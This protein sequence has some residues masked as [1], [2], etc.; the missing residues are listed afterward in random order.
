[1]KI[2]KKMLFIYN[3]H[4]GKAAIK[5]KLSDI[6]ELFVGVDY[7]VTIFSTREKRDAT[8]IVKE[9][10][11][12]Y[13]CIVCS[14]GDG[15]LN[16]VVDGL[17]TLEKR[18]PC[19][20]MP[21]GTVNDFAS[22]LKIPKSIMVAAQNVIDGQPFAYDIG[23]LNNDHF[24]YVAAFGAFTQVAYETPQSFKNVFGKLAYLMDGAMRLANLES[25]HVKV[26]YEGGIVEG[27]F[28]IG[29]ITNSNSVAGLKG[30]TG[31]NVKLNDGLF[32]VVLVK[33]PNNAIELQAIIN[34]LLMREHD[35][36]HIYSFRAS[37]I[38]LSSEEEI[39]WTVDGE[40]GGTYKEAVIENHREAVEFICPKEKPEKKGLVE[41]IIEKEIENERAID[42][43]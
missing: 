36:I 24:N 28:I 41:K 37:H 21:T 19:G 6:V 1:G 39:A 27:R 34:G 33:Q 17:M 3:P 25:Y 32:E 14:G 26:S 13:D 43:E 10:G 35:D 40:Y 23:S 11:E 42:K 8:K 31:K 2:M 38:E 30:L 18:P 16:E 15:T 22:S 12:N 9:K 20:Y 7:E 29:M 5:N 4:A